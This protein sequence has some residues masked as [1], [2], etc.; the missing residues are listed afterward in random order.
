MEEPELTVDGEDLEAIYRLRVEVWL[1]IL[2]AVPDEFA[3]NHWCDDHD[4]H[5]NHWIIR[6]KGEIVAAA[7]L[8]IHENVRDLPSGF[9]YQGSPIASGLLA[10]FNRLVV[11]SDVR[12]EG[13][14]KKLDQVRLDFAREAGCHAAFAY[15]LAASEEQRLLAF[16]RQ[17]FRPIGEINS[18]RL[19]SFGQ[20]TAMV[21]ML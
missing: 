14:S 11:R 6:R 16:M 5:A 2:D 17:G 4:N 20:V 15:S 21:L 10:S 13:L 12:R 7:R 1:P 8:C 3:S 18:L 9:L 19:P